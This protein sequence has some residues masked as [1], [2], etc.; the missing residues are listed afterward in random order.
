[1]VHSRNSSADERRRP[2]LRVVFY[3]TEAGTEPVREWLLSLPRDDRRLIGQDIR[4]AQYGWPV[5]MPLIRKLEPGLW[6]VRTRI[7]GGTARVMF[8]AA[9]TPDRAVT[10]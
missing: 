3:R 2:T 7:T 4:T 5:G 8:T 6:E 9:C 1:M 10:E